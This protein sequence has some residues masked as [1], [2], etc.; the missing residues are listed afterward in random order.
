[1]S[2]GAVGGDPLGE[3]AVADLLAECGEW[4]ALAQTRGRAVSASSL[5][6]PIGRRAAIILCKTESQ[7]LSAFLSRSRCPMVSTPTVPRAS[8]LTLDA[9][10]AADLMTPNPMSIRAE[11]TVPEAVAWLTDKGFSAAPV[12]DESGRPVGVV[13]RTDILVHE[14]ERLRAVLMLDLDR[15]T[16]RDIMT[17]VVFSV[18]PQMPVELVIEQLLK[19]NVHQLYVVDEDHSLIGVISTH[20]VLRRLRG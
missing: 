15:T 1:M 6:L 3:Q 12:I 20:D 5:F 2:E 14:R 9:A 8:R 10:R 13:S 17:P 7:I 18:T 19:L 16:V 11:A 4:I